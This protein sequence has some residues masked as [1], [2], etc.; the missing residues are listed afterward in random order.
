MRYEDEGGGGG[1]AALALGGFGAAVAAAALIGSRY[2]PK[3]GDTKEWYDSLDKPSWNPPN[4][5]FP[6]AWTPLYGLIAWSGYRVW[7]AE[8]SRARS[9]ALALWGTQ[10]GLNA[11]W[12]PIFFGRQSPEAGLAEVGLMLTAIGGY[13]AEAAKVDRPAAWMMAPYLGWVSFATA[14]NAEIVR[15]NPGGRPADPSRA[16]RLQRGR[17]GGR[18]Q[19]DAEDAYDPGPAASHESAPEPAA[20]YAGAF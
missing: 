1:A 19:D 4:W 10:L 11:A 5:L 8:P 17:A 13:T 18:G 3:M 2:N 9:R 12:T 16:D 14:L 7:K 20:D 15:R 6:V